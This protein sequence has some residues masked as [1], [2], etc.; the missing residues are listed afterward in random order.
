MAQEVSSSGGRHKGASVRRR[1]QPSATG[2][3]LTCSVVHGAAR[4]A[5]V[6]TSS[7]TIENA[8]QLGKFSIA[9]RQVGP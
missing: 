7:E 2:K 4:V 5:C 8:P 6:V 9:A 1:G 3:T